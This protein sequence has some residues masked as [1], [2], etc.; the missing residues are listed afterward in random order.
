MNFKMATNLILRGADIDYVNSFGFT[1]LHLCVE[2]K[3]NRSVEYLL[4]KKANPHIMDL[5]E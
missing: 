1:A 2:K 4:F 3:L 5:N